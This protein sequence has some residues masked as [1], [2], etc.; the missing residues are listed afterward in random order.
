MTDAQARPSFRPEAVLFDCDGLLLETE[1][2]WTIAEK[3]L[4]AAPRR[5]ATRIEFKRRLLGTSREVSQALIAEQLGR[6][7][8]DAPGARRRARRALRRRARR[9]RHRADA[10]RASS[11]SRRSTRR[12]PIA[13]ASNNGEQIVRV[14]LELAGVTR[15]LPGGRLR[16]RDAARASRHPDVYLAAAA[17][18]GADPSRCGRA[19]GLGDGR[20]RGTRRRL[21]HDRRAVVSRHDAP[22]ACGVRL[23]RRGRPRRARP[24]RSGSRVVACRVLVVC[25]PDK[26]RGALDARAAAAALARGARRAGAETRELPL[27][28]A[29][30]A[31]STR[32]S[33]AATR[34][35]SASPSAIRS[36]RPVL[37]RLG[38]LDDGVFLVEAAEAVGHA[39]LAAGRA[40]SA[41]LRR[42]RGSA[43]SCAARS[44]AAPGACSSRSAAPSTVDGGLGL[45]GALGALPDRSAATRCSAIRPRTGPASMR[46]SRASSSSR[47]TTLTSRSRGPMALRGCSGR[48][49]GC[50]PTDI[51]ERFDGALARLG[52]RLG[53]DYRGAPGRR[54][55][56]RPRRR[57]LLA[58]RVERVRAPRRSRRS[59]GSTPRCA[60]RASA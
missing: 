45:L 24:R 49:R 2:R 39:R 40:G 30:R 42:A 37:A 56:R 35:S 3:A 19:R 46:D 51:P 48:R 22:G 10:G 29:E 11:C 9:A 16:G 26:L 33:R 7:P 6:P 54:R 15:L 20:D 31:R 27:A 1:S 17:A 43:T 13:V 50:A 38:L 14:A 47:C 44:I 34:P 60:A 18:L 53:A 58:R 28:T 55:G 32:S 57:A 25:A 21:L 36:A 23:A 8:E 4:L 52:T 5:A 12:L 41:A 59:S